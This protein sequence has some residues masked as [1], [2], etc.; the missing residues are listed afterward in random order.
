MFRKWMT[1]NVVSDDSS[2]I[3]LLARESLSEPP[4]RG[5]PN[6][7]RNSPLFRQSLHKIRTGS[8]PGSPRGQPAWG[9]GSDQPIT[10]LTSFENWR[11]SSAHFHQLT[12]RLVA[13]APSSDFV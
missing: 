9:G 7:N 5:A 10:R 13:I 2:S 11:L 6:L 1:F 12:F 4:A 3:T 8:E